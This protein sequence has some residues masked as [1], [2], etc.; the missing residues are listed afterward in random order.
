MILVVKF[1]ADFESLHQFLGRNHGQFHLHL[2]QSWMFSCHQAMSAEAV[3]FF[4]PPVLRVRKDQI[5]LEDPI[6]TMLVEASQ[7]TLNVSHPNSF[8][9][10]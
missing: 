10:H 4:T 9:K 1:R 2:C 6:R 3:E 7:A 8:L 5:P